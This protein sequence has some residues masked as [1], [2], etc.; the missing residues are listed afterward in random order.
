M[1]MQHTLDIKDTGTKGEKLHDPL[2]GSP[3]A[4]GSLKSSPQQAHLI[5]ESEIHITATHPAI[6]LHRHSHH[7][8]VLEMFHRAVK[9][10]VGFQCTT[11][12]AS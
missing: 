4:T 12:H 6:T 8:K 1:N 5:S 10:V 7:L 3:Q 9:S 11:N 2:S